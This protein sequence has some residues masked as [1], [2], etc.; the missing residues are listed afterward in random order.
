MKKMKKFVT[1]LVCL[2][3]AI[4]TLSACTT[5]GN[6]NTKPTEDPKPTTTTAEPTQ[7][8]TATQEPTQEPTES[9][10]TEPSTPEG[11]VI[12]QLYEPVGSIQEINP[13]YLKSNFDTFY[14]AYELGLADI[15]E[16]G[17][18]LYQLTFKGHNFDVC[19]QSGEIYNIDIYFFAN[20]YY[21]S[22]QIY[23]YINGVG[24]VMNVDFIPLFYNQTKHCFVGYTYS[25]GEE[26][27][28]YNAYDGLYEMYYAPEANTW[29][30]E[31]VA[32]PSIYGF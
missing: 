27:N 3:V 6:G 7:E 30:R 28:S 15:V 11:D 13:S 32:D 9:V 8:P 23:I 16:D 20:E 31:S 12:V 1:T 4:A 2:V 24:S 25:S 26:A 18:T 19:T 21:N 22:T 5:T 29:I 14:G 10:T 17:H